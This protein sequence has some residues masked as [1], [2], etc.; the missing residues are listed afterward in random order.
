[1]KIVRRGS[2]LSLN[3]LPTELSYAPVGRSLGEMPPGFV[4]LSRTWP[5]PAGS[6]DAAADA[7]TSWAMHRGSG[8]RVL[9]EPL[10]PG[11]AVLQAV[12]FG[13]LEL[14]APCRVV[15]VVDGGFTYGTLAGHPESGEESFVV[16]ADGARTWLAIRSYSRLASAV[17]RLGTPVARLVQSRA[18]D[19]YAAALQSLL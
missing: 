19:A 17:A 6:F 10:A 15:A 5:L 14:L 18:V 3:G 13:P 16:H 12:P 2:P 1:V 7:V 11:S 9:A 8:L 4:H